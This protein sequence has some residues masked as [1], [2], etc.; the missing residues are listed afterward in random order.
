MNYELEVVDTKEYESAKIYHLYLP[1]YH[2]MKQHFHH[3]VELVY[4]IQGSFMGYI[5][6]KA[7]HVCENEDRKSTRLNSSHEWISRMP[8]SA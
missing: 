7:Y 8:S 1:H 3:N 5:N 4:L 2:Y 6:G